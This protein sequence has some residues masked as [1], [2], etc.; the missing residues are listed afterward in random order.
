[1]DRD[2]SL[3]NAA[4]AGVVSVGD[5]RYI[6]KC[7]TVLWTM[8]SLVLTPHQS[9]ALN[10][11]FC[12]PFA[13]LPSLAF[14]AGPW[15]VGGGG[16][17]VVLKEQTFLPMW[18]VINFLSLIFECTPLEMNYKSKCLSELPDCT[19]ILIKLLSYQISLQLQFLKNFVLSYFGRLFYA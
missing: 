14:T 11:H 4:K 3:F 8:C 10:C 12:S 16:R 5:G 13:G 19:C 9:F 1:M 6:A 7:K 2:S 15:A 18:V 17:L